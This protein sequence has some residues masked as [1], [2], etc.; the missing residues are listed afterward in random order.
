MAVLHAPVVWPLLEE[1]LVESLKG[2]RHRVGE[3]GEHVFQGGRL[4]HREVLQTVQMFKTQ[5]RQTHLQRGGI[6][7]H[8]GF[9]SPQFST[10]R[11]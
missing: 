2:I 5:I 4:G 10:N 9:P 8:A 11:E 7:V 1:P 6:I 3:C